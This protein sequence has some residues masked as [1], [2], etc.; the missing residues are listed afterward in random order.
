[1]NVQESRLIGKPQSPSAQLAT[2]LRQ[3]QWDLDHVAFNL[4]NGTVSQPEREKLADALTRLAELLRG[5]H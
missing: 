4:P 5:A 2:V 3:A 1:M